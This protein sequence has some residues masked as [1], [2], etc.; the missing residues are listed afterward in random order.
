MTRN[1]CR[2][3]LAALLTI[4]GAAALAQPAKEAPTTTANPAAAQPA[5]EQ[6]MPQLPEGWT[7]EDMMAC[8]QAG[9]PGEQHAFLAKVAGTWQGTTRMWMGPDATEPMESTCT[10]VMTPIMDGRYMKCETT[11][12]MPGMGAFLG[13]GIYGYDNVA[14]KFVASWIDNHS[15]GILHGT[16]ELSPDGKT[17]TWSFTYHCPIAKK[18]TVMREIE[19]RLSDD[20]FVLEMHGVDPKTGKEYKMM[21]I[22]YTRV[23]TSTSAAAPTT[24]SSN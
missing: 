13:Q 1:T 3:S 23:S 18:P 8:V 2:I 16:G 4:A 22:A 20:A 14:Q 9:T 6:G 19:R 12:E 5:G 15:T 21:E 10:T 24:T 11:G 17:M 7:M